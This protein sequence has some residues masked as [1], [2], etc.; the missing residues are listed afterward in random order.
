[1]KHTAKSYERPVIVTISTA[2]VL[3]AV[4]PALASVYAEATPA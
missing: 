3:T 4:G 1:M 2:E